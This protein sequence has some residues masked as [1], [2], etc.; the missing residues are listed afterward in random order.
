MSDHCP[1][2]EGWHL[3]TI[4]YEDAWGYVCDDCGREISPEEALILIEEEV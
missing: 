2:C 1:Y 4:Y 3:R